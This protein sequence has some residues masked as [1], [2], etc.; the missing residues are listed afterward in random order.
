MQ[1]NS[2][3]PIAHIPGRPRNEITAEFQQRCAYC[4]SPQ[5]LIGAFF[6]VNHIIPQ[7]GGDEATKENLCW[8]CPL[9]NRYKGSQTVAKDPKTDQVVSPTST[10][11]D[12]A[13]QME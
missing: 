3:K 11:M 7:V 6:E 1:L 9:C 8:C 13:F 5:E 4:Q 10:K 12:T 2:R